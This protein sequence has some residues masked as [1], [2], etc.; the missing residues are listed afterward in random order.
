MRIEHNFDLTNYNSYGIHARCKRAFFPETENDIIELYKL[1]NDFILLG[2]GYNII[3][4]KEYYDVDFLIFNGNFD[5]IEVD[6]IGCLIIAEAGT[7][8]LEISEIAQKYSL[9]GVEFYYDIP[10]SVGGA[11]VMNAGTKEG[12]TKDIL[13]KVR[14][15]DLTDMTVNEKSNENLELEY[16]NSFFQKQ[17]DKVILKAWFKLEKGNR[18]IIRSVMEASKE[19]RWKMQPREYPN[20]GSV[21]KR[22]PGYYVGPMIDELKLKGY[23]VGGA[24]ISKKHGGFIVN[25]NNATG[26]DI[27]AIV[28]H[29]QARVK[30]KFNVNLEIEQRI[31]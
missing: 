27:I 21:F 15:L 24:E 1:K 14:Y 3:L 6:D 28:K 26:M 8:I 5:S 29:V 4:S 10:S 11:V 20:G 2:G 23:R 18:S 12:E 19:R 9:T 16:R 22:P 25:V 13:E 17:K 7:T 30:E 31:I